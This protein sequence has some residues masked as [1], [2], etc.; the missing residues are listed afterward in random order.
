MKPIPD[1]V[2]QALLARLDAR[3]GAAESRPASSLP[4]D[5]AGPSARILPFLPR[6]SLARTGQ[7]V[8]A[9]IDL[10]RVR[11]E[12]HAKRTTSGVFH[13]APRL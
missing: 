8:D 4:E 9:P 2:V 11:D 5:D 12:T 1:D 6:R 10:A 7:G 3:L 13:Y